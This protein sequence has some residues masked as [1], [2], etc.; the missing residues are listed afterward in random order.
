RRLEWHPGA[1]SSGNSS[2]PALLIASPLPQ[3]RPVAE[4]QQLQLRKMS[5]SSD[6]AARSTAAACLGTA[7]PMESGQNQ[8]NTNSTAA[9]APGQNPK[10]RSRDR[11]AS[12]FSDS[13]GA[14]LRGAQSAMA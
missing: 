2:V 6:T 3:I 11:K 9:V 1:G 14:V 4:P 5:N 13:R 12:P 8:S 7:V 10:P